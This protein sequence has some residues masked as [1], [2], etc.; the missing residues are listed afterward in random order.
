MDYKS[1]YC[2]IQIDEAG[3]QIFLM[4]G[5][6]ISLQYWEILENHED[7]ISFRSRAQQTAREDKTTK[8]RGQMPFPE[9]LASLIYAV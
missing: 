2:K 3:S 6:R 7:M 4:T 9:L 5:D 8:G 1:A